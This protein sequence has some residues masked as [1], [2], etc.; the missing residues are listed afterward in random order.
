MYTIRR[1]KLNEMLWREDLRRAQNTWENLEH[2]LLRKI[3]ANE[4]R[5][6]RLD[7]GTRVG[8]FKVR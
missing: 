6:K 7:M 2:A 4:A 3:Q 5:S 8:F 1:N